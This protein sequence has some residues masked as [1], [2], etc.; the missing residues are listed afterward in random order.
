[1]TTE[2]IT[3]LNYVA[4]HNF[5]GT[6]QTFDSPDDLQR[7]EEAGSIFCKLLSHVKFSSQRRKGKEAGK[8]VSELTK[9]KLQWVIDSFNGDFILRLL[10]IIFPLDY[11]IYITVRS[12]RP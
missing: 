7:P 5:S 6:L 9:P 4:L 8:A 12:E 3:P 11:H 10:D 2:I 1:M